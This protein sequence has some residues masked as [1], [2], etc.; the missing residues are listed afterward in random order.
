MTTTL[1][2]EKNV[3]IDKK[4]ADI[5]LNL[6]GIAKGILRKDKV[7]KKELEPIKQRIEE[8]VQIVNKNKGVVIKTIPTKSADGKEFYVMGVDSP[9]NVAGFGAL[10]SIENKNR[11]LFAAMESDGK[12]EVTLTRNKAKDFA[13]KTGMSHWR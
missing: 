2:E 11:G 8:L 5:N 7:S 6:M 3:S 9:K 13:K 12:I 4:L 1:K 10:V